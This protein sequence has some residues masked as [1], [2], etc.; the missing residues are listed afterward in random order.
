MKYIKYGFH[1]FSKNM[2]LN[3]ILAV[4]LAATLVVVNIT[5]GKYNLQIQS[6][7]Q[8]SSVE[9]S[10]GVYFMPTYDL[11]EYS[12]GDEE[13]ASAEASS[14]EDDSAETSVAN[15]PV[16]KEIKGVSSVATIEQLAFKNTAYAADPIE[17]KAYSDILVEKFRPV[18][19]KGVWLTDADTQNGVI[20]AVVVGNRG[21]FRLGD[22]VDFTTYGDVAKPCKIRIV[23]IMNSLSMQLDFTCSGEKITCAD[24]FQVYNDRFKE[25]PEFLMKQSDIKELKASVYVT[26]SNCMA[27]FKDTLPEETVNANLAVLKKYGFVGTFSELYAGG[28]QTVKTEFRSVLSIAVCLLGIAVIGLISMTILNS[29]KHMKLFSILYIC[30]CRWKSLTLI[31]AGYLFCVLLTALL[32]VFAV[33]CIAVVTDLFFKMQ[34][35]LLADNLWASGAV[36]LLVGA[37]AMIPPFLYLKNLSPVTILKQQGE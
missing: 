22:V 16:W 17:A 29:L 19:E 21:L 15:A 20:P 23:G 24:L 9:R 31:F 13:N 14:S 26:Q 28:V 1:I 18:L 7:R 6:V 4:Q 35:L 2:L 3:G 25:V 10:S 37:A 8:F 11:F 27:F 32:G 30:G 12:G 34:L 33:G 36:L 5:V